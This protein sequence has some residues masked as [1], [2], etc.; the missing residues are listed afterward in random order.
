MCRLHFSYQKG[1]NLNSIGK[2]LHLNV[3]SD[4]LTNGG[5]TSVESFLGGFS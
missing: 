5:W 3:L 2:L 1:I 4:E